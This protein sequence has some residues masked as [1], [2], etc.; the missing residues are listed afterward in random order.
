MNLDDVVGECNSVVGVRGNATSIEN[1]G[2]R[3][4]VV[5]VYGW[6]IDFLSTDAAIH[7]SSGCTFLN[8]A[9]CFVRPINIKYSIFLSHY[10]RFHVY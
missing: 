2:P 6:E 7:T 5:G 4:V 10:Y 9:G 3:K 1:Y 8:W